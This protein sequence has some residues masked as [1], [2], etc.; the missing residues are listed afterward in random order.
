MQPISYGRQWIDDHDIA[1]VVAVLKSDFL[2]QGPFVKQFEDDLCAYTGAKYCVSL[3]N[4]TAALHL[5]VAALEIEE[6]A[7]G[8][9][10]PL[11]FMASSNCFLYNNIKPVFADIVPDT[12]NIDPEEIRKRMTSQTKIIIP[13]HF[14]G[15][16]A[17]MA[18]IARFAEE[19]NISI[20]EDA[21]H[22]IGSRYKNG[23]P[24]GNCE[25]SAM[26][27]F[28]FH[29]VKTITTGE[30]GA[31][32]T[33]NKEI[34]ERLILLRSHGITRSPERLIKNDGPWYHEM[35]TLGYN[36]RLTDI[37][38][39]L[40]SSQ[41]KKLDQFVARR[42]EIVARYNE[43]F[44][45]LTALQIPPHSQDDFSSYHLYVIRIDYSRLKITRAQFIDSL[46]QR[47][48]LTQVHYIPVH[49]QPYYQEKFGY[50]QGDYPHAEHY[51]EKAL[52]LPLYPRLTDD[53]VQSVIDAIK[54]LTLI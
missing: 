52:S 3:A 15:Q 13:V 1:A 33:N 30:G 24:V 18:S 6:G 46:K 25:Y 36:Y 39:A 43:A 26:T 48:I 16:P 37:Q 22:A 12:F 32:T 11:T 31:I 28:S 42:R 34:Y 9:T 17:D 35:R 54:E 23:R 4:G 7:E 41:L 20:I 8:I 27:I 53:N 51:Y 5:A 29:P 44:K 40:G 21:A 14:A 49:T 19:N 10:S 45:D 38:C 50:K 47:S 2:T